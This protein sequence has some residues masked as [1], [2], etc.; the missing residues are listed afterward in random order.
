MKSFTSSLVDLS[1][2]ESQTKHPLS[3][4]VGIMNRMNNAIL[5]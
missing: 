2:S 4:I 5:H 1:V 3:A